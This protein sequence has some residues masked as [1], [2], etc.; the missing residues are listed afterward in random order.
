VID[1]APRKLK[2]HEELYVTHDLELVVVIIALKLWRHYLVGRSF[3]LKMDHQS[4]K[5]IFTQRDLKAR[6][7]HG[8]SL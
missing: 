7:R 2:K 4:L 6:K 1:Y 3:E 8:V 5:H